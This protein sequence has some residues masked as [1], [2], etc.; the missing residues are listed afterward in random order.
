[1]LAFAGQV[2]EVVNS[3]EY[4]ALIRCNL[5]SF[6]THALWLT[7]DLKDLSKPF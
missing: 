2:V 4:K 1:M 6:R 3:R 5:V 7:F